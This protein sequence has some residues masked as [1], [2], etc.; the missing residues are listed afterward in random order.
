MIIDNLIKKNIINLKSCAFALRERVCFIK[1]ITSI[2][3]CD[4]PGFT[5]FNYQLLIEL[6]SFSPT[7]P[8][9]TIGEKHQSK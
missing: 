3:N 5:K 7:K 6:M 8:I 9:I 2:R 1:T 4:W